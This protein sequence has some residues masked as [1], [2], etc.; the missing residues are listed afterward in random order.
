MERPSTPEEATALYEAAVATN[1]PFTRG[2][3]LQIKGHEGAHIVTQDGRILLDCNGHVLAHNMVNDA[4]IRR[5]IQEVLEETGT[6][7]LAPGMTHPEVD[8]AK[9]RIA[10]M[11]ENEF[12]GGSWEVDLMSSGTRANEDSLSVGRAVLGGEQHVLALRE[13]YHG[14]G[15]MRGV[16]GHSSWNSRGTLRLGVPMTLLDFVQTDEGR[17]YTADFY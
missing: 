10:G 4:P 9:V 6:G 13:G 15:A 1:G 14:S 5:H 8:L 2:Q 12:G 3:P 17:D 7:I 16:V 11:I